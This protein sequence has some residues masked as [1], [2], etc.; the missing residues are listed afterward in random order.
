MF[1]SNSIEWWSGTIKTQGRVYFPGGEGRVAPVAP[2]DV[3]AVAYNALTQ[4]GHSGKIYE[5]T[6]PELLS[7]N[8]MATII[9]NLLGKPVK[10]ISVPLVAAGLQMFWFGLDLKL[11]K[12][13]M[14]LASE[15]RSGRG[16]ILT[17]TVQSVTGDSAQTFEAWCRENVD[18]FH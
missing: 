11:I 5:L 2:C 3:A 9:G 15:L 12:A 8:D 1:M 4:S 10:Y 13:F 14:Q 7:I 16:A 17:D 6:G 18:A